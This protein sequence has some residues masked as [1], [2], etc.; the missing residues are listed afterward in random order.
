MCGLA[1][2]I[3]FDGPIN[4][5]AVERVAGLLRHRGPDALGQWAIDWAALAHCRLA[6]VDPLGSHQPMFRDE[7]ALA[8]AGEVFDHQTTRK[9]LARRGFASHSEGDTEVVLGTYLLDGI[10]GVSRLPGQF[11]AA[12]IDTNTRELWLIRDRFGIAPLHY[13]QV[14]GG[15]AF[16]SELKALLALRGGRADV[17]E[18]SVGTFVLTRSTPSPFTMYKGVF[19]LPPGHLLRFTRGSEPEVRRYWSLPERARKPIFGRSASIEHIGVA[20]RRAVLRQSR[21]DAPVGCLLSGG[22][23]SAIVAALLRDSLGYAPPS[24][25]IGVSEGGCELSDAARSAEFVGTQH[26]E[27]ILEPRHYLNNMERLTWHRDAPLSEPADIAV[28]MIAQ[29]AAASVRV[30]LTGEGCDELFVGY[31]KY[32]VAWSNAAAGALPHSVRGPLFESMQRRL[33]RSAR[34]C[35]ILLRALSEPTLDDRLRGWF[36]SFTQV[37][38]RRIWPGDTHADDVAPV[39]CGSTLD[40][41][42]QMDAGTWLSDNLLER[43]DRMMMASSVEPRA[44]FLDPLVVEAAM[45]MP[46]RQCA[47]GRGDKILLRAAARSLGL[48]AIAD[49]PKRGFPLPIGRWFRGPLR[50]MLFDILQA[51]GSLWRA[52]GVNSEVDRLLLRHDSG[53]ADESIRLWTLLSLEVWRGVGRGLTMPSVART[54]PIQV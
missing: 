11:A 7:V 40:R 15:I 23:D 20:L 17:D 37:E 45:Q 32:R 47:S 29:R 35:H 22:V 25:V 44:P 12:I 42:L 3:C 36:A 48:G 24:F 27:V 34:R 16:A 6:V 53:L 28:Y 10:T 13:A 41:M 50:P 51:K 43:A 9:S 46:S 38:A 8:F 30:L 2:L 4:P 52:L 1:G 39:V 33:P 31:P 21:A 18:R 49:R 19:K 5:E 14:P 26:T 54:Q